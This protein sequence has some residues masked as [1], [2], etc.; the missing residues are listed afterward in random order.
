MCANIFHVS[1]SFLLIPFELDVQKDVTLATVC[2]TAIVYSE[3]G[4]LNGLKSYYGNA[5]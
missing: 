4:I 2:Q 3:T 5:Q 1:T